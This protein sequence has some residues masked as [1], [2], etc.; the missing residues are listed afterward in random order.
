MIDGTTRS[1]QHKLVFKEGGA[2]SVF[3]IEEPVP[4]SCRNFGV[5]LELVSSKNHDG[6]ALEHADIKN[7]IFGD[8]AELE[9][10]GFCGVV[11]LHGDTS[12]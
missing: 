9:Q 10:Q 3:N 8:V 4:L 5:E 2:Q 1:L 12:C 6:S 11:E 7:R